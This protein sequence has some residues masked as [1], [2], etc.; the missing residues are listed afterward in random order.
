MRTNIYILIVLLLVGKISFSQSDTTYFNR[1]SKSLDP[2]FAPFYHGVASGDA[3]HDRVIIWTRVTSLNQLIDSIAVEWYIGTDTLCNNVVNQGIAYT[4]EN[5][6][7]TVKIDVTGLMPNTYYYYYFKFD[8]H[9]SVIGRTKTTSIESCENLRLILISGS[10]Y[11][12]GF[13]NAYN[14]MTIR[15]DID[16]IVH[17]GDYIY[18]YET[19]HYGEHPD[20]F[21]E[22]NNEIITLA[23]YRMRYSHYKLDPDLRYAHQQYVWYVIWDDHEVANNSWK[24]GAENHDEN[25][26]GN[27]ST[28]K[29]AAKQAFFE[30]IPIREN[31][32]THSIKRTINFGNLA[33]MILIDTRHEDRDDPEGLAVNDPNKTMLGAAQYTWFTN[34]LLSAQYQ[35]SVIWKLIGNQVMFAPLKVFG[36]VVNKDQWDGYNYERQRIMDYIYGM[37]IKNTV[38]LTGDI[39]TSWANDVPNSTLGSYGANGQGSAFVE[40]VTPS[41]TSPSTNGFLAGL[42]ASALYPM[43]THMKWI[44]LE[45]RGYVLLDITPQ[46]VQGD[47]YFVDN[48]ESLQ[49]TDFFAKG[50]YV[51][52]NESYLKE[53]TTPSLRIPPYQAF[54]PMYPKQN[55]STFAG[56]EAKLVLLGVYPNPFISELKIQ[57]FQNTTSELKIDIFNIYGKKV[58]TKQYPYKTVDLGYINIPLDYL[59]KGEY[60]IVIS[61]NNTTIKKKVIKL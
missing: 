42:G 19:N 22:P 5:K 13:Y 3:L 50:Y 7:F 49:Y 40:Y 29:N 24:N 28:R 15:N 10:N 31:G 61:S 45:H 37:N 20:R 4:S 55:N 39:H 53:N 60:L 21:L 35:D 57:Y 16:A 38:M 25:T 36:N 56:N 41:V 14:S 59:S 11:N 51:N 2:M 18:E 30:W 34:Q 48:I 33:N 58:F 32:N 17:L 1:L 9:N 47:W 43:N 54:A 23:D 27:Y 52:N 26:E 44:D 46:R 6:D 8:E 12:S